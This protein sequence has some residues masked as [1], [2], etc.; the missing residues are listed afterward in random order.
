MADVFHKTYRA[1][2]LDSLYGNSPAPSRKRNT[3]AAF[4]A[5]SPVESAE[6][7]REEILAS[8]DVDEPVTKRGRYENLGLA[9][10]QAKIFEEVM[11]MSNVSLREPQRHWRPNG[12]Y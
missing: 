3:D 10:S 6:M 12:Q 8:K 4:A 11:G 2:P 7:N 9:T 5:P 1:S